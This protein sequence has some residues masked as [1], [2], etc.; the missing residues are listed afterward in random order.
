MHLQFLPLSR[1]TLQR[2]RAISGLYC[3]RHCAAGTWHSDCCARELQHTLSR[4]SVMLTSTALLRIALASGFALSIAST[5]YA[6]NTQSPGNQSGQ[7]QATPGTSQDGASAATADKKSKKKPGAPGAADQ[8]QQNSTTG[9]TDSAHPGNANQVDKP[10]TK[11]GGTGTQSGK[12]PANAP[13]NAGGNT[14]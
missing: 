8:S 3:R 9:Q 12:N 5:S 6:Q 1:M 7:N 13:D 11:P 4:R 2:A 10:T 14:R